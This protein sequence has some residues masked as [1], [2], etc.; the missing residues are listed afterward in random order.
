ML[1]LLL[2]IKLN[3]LLE[4]YFEAQDGRNDRMSNA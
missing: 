1:V 3:G 4:K 2:P